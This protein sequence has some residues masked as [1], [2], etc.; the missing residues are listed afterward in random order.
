MAS[1]APFGSKRYDSACVAD[2]KVI[3]VRSSEP[4]DRREALGLFR[5]F[6]V[7]TGN[8]SS[9]RD[10]A[11][12]DE[13]PE[14][15]FDEICDNDA[16]RVALSFASTESERRYLLTGVDKPTSGDTEAAS[17]APEE[18]QDHGS[19]NLKSNKA[20]LKQAE[21]AEKRKRKE[22]KRLAKRAKKEAKKLKKERKE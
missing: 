20:D 4:V 1:A 16:Y 17:E 8:D 3:A 21:K 14:E 15:D 12:E 6:L 2:A 13:F 7:L 18:I 22:E 19:N 10:E 9:L 11:G 5:K